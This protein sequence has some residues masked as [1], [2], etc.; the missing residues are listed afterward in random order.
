M[1]LHCH[2]LVWMPD[3]LTKPSETMVMISLMLTP[4]HTVWP[5]LYH[6]TIPA[7]DPFPHASFYC[8]NLGALGGCEEG[9][10]EWEGLVRGGCWPDWGVRQY[11]GWDF[12]HIHKRCEASVL[13]WCRP[14]Q[15]QPLLTASLSS[16][17]AGRQKLSAD[18]SRKVACT[19]TQVPKCTNRLSLGHLNLHVHIV[20]HQPTTPT[21]YIKAVLP[22]KLCGAAQAFQVISLRVVL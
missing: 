17:Q 6:S 1:V 22:F 2:L 3:F 20:I 12:P 13:C 15:L 19:F 11:A 14:H 9:N 5:R 10:G 16:E 4:F 18:Q 21:N 7:F 8:P